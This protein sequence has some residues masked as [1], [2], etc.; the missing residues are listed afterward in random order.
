MIMPTELL[1]VVSW[2]LVTEYPT[3]PGCVLQ[4][5]IGNEVENKPL[6]LK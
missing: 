1:I 5:L 4:R 2:T 3:L 6:N